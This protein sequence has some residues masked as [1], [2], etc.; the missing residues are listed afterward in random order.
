MKYDKGASLMASVMS[1]WLSKPPWDS[2][3]DEEIARMLTIQILRILPQNMRG[4]FS[5]NGDNGL[6]TDDINVYYRQKDKKQIHLLKKDNGYIELKPFVSINVIR[7]YRNGR[8]AMDAITLAAFC[9]LLGKTTDDFFGETLNN[10]RATN[11]MADA[12]SSDSNIVMNYSSDPCN[13]IEAVKKATGSIFF[14]GI[15][16]T[17]L[18]YALRNVLVNDTDPKVTI[19]FAAVDYIKNNDIMTFLQDYFGPHREK[20]YK[21]RDAFND[22]VEILK[23]RQNT[24]FLDLDIFM[25]VSYF[26]ID[27]KEKTK[28]S[29]IQAKHYLRH[30]YENE[31]NVLYYTAHQGTKLYEQYR[32]QILLIEESGGNLGYIDKLGLP[33]SSIIEETSIHPCQEVTKHFLE[34]IFGESS[35][36]YA[37]NMGKQANFMRALFPNNEPKLTCYATF[38]HLEVQNEQKF[39]KGDLTFFNPN[40][41]ICRIEAEFENAQRAKEKYEGFAIMLFPNTD[42]G[43][44]W[45]FLKRTDDKTAELAILSFKLSADS[46]WNTRMAQVLTINSHTFDPTVFR[47]LLSKDDI[48]DDK[49]IDKYFSGYMN[50]NTDEILIQAL[51]F[52]IAIKYFENKDKFDN[53]T[54]ID[55]YNTNP[56]L[57]TIIGDLKKHCTNPDNAI[58]EI[59]RII[60]ELK[61]YFKDSD[62]KTIQNATFALSD[63]KKNSLGEVY[64]INGEYNNDD[65]LFNMA[66]VLEN[67]F[68]FSWLL[69]RGLSPTK[70]KLSEKLNNIIDYLD[71]LSRSSK[72]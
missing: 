54:I 10:I 8:T 60:E 51:F 32:N 28:F 72:E 12:A 2:M 16:M 23:N 14:S 55:A 44:C 33:V 17:F 35:A 41:N 36:N 48:K 53:H 70:N 42:R 64:S 4:E 63:V 19:N 5:E 6:T 37:F 27:Y 71:R 13:Y 43:S 30:K 1:K 69:D 34:S 9:A 20:W 67:P 49:I 68:L 56:E 21:H 15:G 40:D 38:L 11:D 62:E 25:P 29:F 26:A 7:D 39:Q 18:D 22:H 24:S 46:N 45:C 57:L 66:K 65:G 50:L 3:S 59:A 47:M 31:V 61:N 52:E 58:E